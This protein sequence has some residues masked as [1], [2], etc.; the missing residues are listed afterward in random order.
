MFIG[1]YHYTIDSKKRLAI[2]VKFRL[3]LGK[4]AFITRGLEQSL[5]LYTQKDWKKLAAKLSRL[6]FSKSDARGFSRLMLAGAMEVELD[7]AGRIL[8]PDY[9]KDYASLQKSITMVGVFDRVEIWNEE[10]WSKYKGQMEKEVGDM[11][12]R[13]GELGV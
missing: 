1:E 6:P 8:I 9:L 4:K 2:P 13:L 7:K 10:K 3:E 11:A 12:E 5:F